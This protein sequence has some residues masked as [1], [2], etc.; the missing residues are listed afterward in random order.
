M[1]APLEAGGKSS[2]LDELDTDDLVASRSDRQ[3]DAHLI[4]DL[5]SD[6]GARQGRGNAD[7][8]VV[9]IRFLR[10]HDSVLHLF[11]AVEVQK[12]H[13]RAEPDPRPAELGR[14][15]HFGA[16]ELVLDVFDPRLD[17]ALPLFRGVVL[18]ILTQI[19]VLAR[20]PNFSGNLGALFL[21]TGQL[22]F[23]LGRAEGR[24]RDFFHLSHGSAL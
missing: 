20:H 16:T 13:G 8:S 22:F 9:E 3:L 19:S 18:G 4:T 21:Q 6:Q 24:H 12:L 7:G 14:I 17:H 2:I 1:P 11:V 15:D 23:E 10:P 5:F